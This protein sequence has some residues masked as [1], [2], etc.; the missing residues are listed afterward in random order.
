MS[1]NNHGSASSVVNIQE[2]GSREASQLGTWD[3]AQEQL[4]RGRWVFRTLLR[5]LS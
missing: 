1:L 5:R 2:R 3:L 4:L